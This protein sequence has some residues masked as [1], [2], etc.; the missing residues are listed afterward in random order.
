MVLRKFIFLFILSFSLYASEGNVC[1][2]SLGCFEGNVCEE[3]YGCYEEYFPNKYADN[4]YDDEY[5]DDYNY[6]YPDYDEASL[7]IFSKQ[8]RIRNQINEITDCI[9]YQI[10]Y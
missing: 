6:G 10:C 8:M 2:E 9:V 5:W 4:S 3:T 1:D 7:Y